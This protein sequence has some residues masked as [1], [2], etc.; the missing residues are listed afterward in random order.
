MQAEGALA[1]QP[2][3]LGTNLSVTLGQITRW[4]AGG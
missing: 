4:E 2:E 1:E 3:V